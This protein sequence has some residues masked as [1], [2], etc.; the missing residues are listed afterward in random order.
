MTRAGGIVVRVGPAM[1]EESER[2]GMGELRLAA[3]AAVHR[4]EDSRH[5][6]RGVPES[7]GREIAGHGLVEIGGDHTADR[8]GL[9]LNLV[10]ARAVRLEHRG[11]H[12]TEARAGRT[13]RR[14]GNR[15]RRRT[16]RRRG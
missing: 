14:A 1:K 13:C 3:E 7:R 8:I 6:A 5:S 11:Q 2:A 15:C 10:A 12:A 4:V 16:P 9:G